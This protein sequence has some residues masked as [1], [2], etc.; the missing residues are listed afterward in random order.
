MVYFSSDSLCATMVYSF[1]CPTFSLLTITGDTYGYN[2][3]S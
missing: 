3:A 2:E 1:L